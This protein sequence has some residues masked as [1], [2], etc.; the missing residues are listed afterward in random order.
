VRDRLEAGVALVT[1]AS[2]GIGA[3]FARR[4]AARGFD[5]FLVA[6]REG[7][8][9]DLAAEVNERYRV[10]T[11]VIVADLSRPAD[12]E[13]V[14][15][16]L[17]QGRPVDV[18]VNN[19]G[20]GTVG[21]F[22][23][24]D[25]GRQLD[26]VRVHVVASVR[27]IRAALPGMISRGR[28]T[29]INVSSLAAFIPTPENA[30]YSATKAYL[31][32]FSEALDKELKGT[33]VD[34]QVLVPGFTLTEFYDSPEFR[35]VDMRAKV[36]SRV[37]GALWLTADEVVARSLESLGGGRLVCAPGFGTRLVIALSRIG[38]SPLVSG[39]LTARFGEELRGSAQ[40]NVTP[41]RHE[42]RNERST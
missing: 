42:E 35:R 8:L 5:L 18:L 11:D 32:A 36:R 10:T 28:G 9:R 30:T 29:I 21:Y 19:A 15:A 33:G 23:E 13:G 7:R 34:V 1:G 6:R 4:L 16:R 2:S 40:D 25:L 20:F 26:M 3:A 41:P 24:V 37:P 12:V 38:L 14:E 17:A 31:T 22:G 27:L 39:V